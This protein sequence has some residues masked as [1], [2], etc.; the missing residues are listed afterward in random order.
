MNYKEIRPKVKTQLP[1]QY[2]SAVL[3]NRC[4]KMHGVDVRVI[5][6]AGNCKILIFNI[7][8]YIVL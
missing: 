4:M 8:L 5:Y 3:Y 1:R 7:A 6:H 2:F